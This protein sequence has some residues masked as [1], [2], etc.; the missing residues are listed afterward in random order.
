MKVKDRVNG[1]AAKFYAVMG[2]KAKKGFDF[3]ES[4]HPQERACYRMAEIAWEEF[5]G[6]RPDYAEDEE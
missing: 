4:K 5:M 3:S 1:L 6:D 2:Y